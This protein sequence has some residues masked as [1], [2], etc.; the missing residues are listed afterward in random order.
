MVLTVLA[1]VQH[2][3]WDE[4]D[5]KW[6][7]YDLYFKSVSNQALYPPPSLFIITCLQWM[8][9]SLARLSWEKIANYHFIL[10]HM[11]EKSAI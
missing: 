10:E 5:P 2:S 7:T 8:E 6:W 11:V 9:N 4:S 1:F 3:G